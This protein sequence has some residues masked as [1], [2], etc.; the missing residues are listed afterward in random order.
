[1]REKPN[2]SPQEQKSELDELR[3]M[4]DTSLDVICTIDS[5][6]HFIRISKACEKVWGYR[7]DELIGKIYLDLV[8][9]DDREK[10][11]QAAL[12]ILHGQNTT[13]FE[14][15]YIRKD[16]SSVPLLWSGRW[17]EHTKLVYCVAKDATSIVNKFETEKE[18]VRKN[19][20]ILLNNTDRLIWSFDKDKNLIEANNIFFQSLKE[21]S[22]I[23]IKRGQNL[24][25]E[26]V[27]GNLQ[28]ID[29]WSELYDIAL[30]GEEIEIELEVPNQSGT[31]SSIWLRTEFKPIK[32]NN[33]VVGG[34]CQTFDITARIKT[35]EEVKELNKKL[36]ESHR[37]AKIGY[38]ELNLEK[39]EIYW[40]DEVF[41]IWGIDRKAKP[42]Y[43]GFLSTIHPEDRE[44]FLFRSK[45]ALSGKKPLHYEHRILLPDGT[46]KWVLEQGVLKKNSNNKPSFKG[47]VQDITKQKL[48]EEELKER[49]EY[50]ESVLE[51]MPIG[52][53][54]STIN[55]GTVIMT[56]PE[57]NKVYGWPPGKLK[58]VGSFLKKIFPNQENRA[59]MIKMMTGDIEKGDI[60]RMQWHDIKITTQ[61]GNEKYIDVKNIPLPEQNV[62]ISTAIDVTEKKKHK[63]DIQRSYEEKNEILESISEAFYALNDNYEFT[64]INQ[65]TLN[66]FN[67][68]S[69]EL[70]GCNLFD[71]FPELKKTIF[72]TRL[73]QVKSTQKPARFEFHYK[74]YDAW[75]DENIYPTKDGFSVFFKDITDRKNIER[76]L[77]E[78]SQKNNEILESISDGFFALDQDFKFTYINE[79]AENLL[80]IKKGKSLNKSIWDIFKPA[81]DTQLY[82]E[83]HK[84]LQLKETRT[85]EYY[86]TPL[87]TWFLSKVYP[88]EN[89]LSVYF[90]DINEEKRNQA[91]MEKLHA[92]LKERAIKLEQIN[93]ELEQFAFI[94]SHD[95]QEPLRMITSFMSQLKNKYS[96]SLDEKANTYIDYAVDGG[97]RMRQIIVDLLEYSRA[98]NDEIFTEN[99]NPNELVEGILALY[100]DTIETKNA[101]VVVEK[102]PII[103]Y[104][105]TGLNQ[106]FQN[107]IGNALKYIPK[108]RKPKL[109]IS[110]EENDIH[111]EFI[112][113][114]NGIGIQKEYLDDIFVIF[115]RLHTK[116][117][118]SGSGLGLAICKKIVEKYGGK[119][120]VHSQAEKGS[121]FHFTVPK[122]KITYE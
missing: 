45:E 113:S 56:N 33:I 120:W 63:E 95:L 86:Y 8:H 29:R 89:G 17:D 53:S 66:L 32:E 25:D 18:K 85:F 68:P 20:D 38:W 62:M 42:D 31:G 117:E 22:G 51:Y 52:I 73:E 28:L 84:A 112:I 122:N 115:K 37:I 24:I 90:R 118:Y 7:E 103:S 100:R 114:D 116:K 107:L 69:E 26:K 64:Y 80:A 119:I 79:E 23:E 13:S 43:D 30:S 21:Y 59:K 11:S 35:E 91:K 50:I 1:M 39:N 71:E 101:T 9:P 82:H 4:I 83:Y 58:N 46:V 81:V 87:K 110:C 105:K 99:L 60:S 106:V 111:Y 70:I 14:N 93:K 6:G 77:K 88:S 40:S 12:E 54:V 47:T 16:G 48:V 36:N 2:K 41:R 96:K 97:S 78:T 19:K 104:S 27:V 94:A 76:E 98:G 72:F 55:D 3:L 5:E 109:K 121:H 75:F 74:L 102:L 65:T 49:T 15:R 10:T 34:V 57:F 92:E 44:E 61:D 108:G 67:K